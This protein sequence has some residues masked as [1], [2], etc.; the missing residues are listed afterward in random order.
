MI[1]IERLENAIRK[2]RRWGRKK[3]LI[4]VRG[5]GSTDQKRVHV[6]QKYLNSNNS[7]LNCTTQTTYYIAKKPAPLRHILDGLPGNVL[8]T[9]SKNRDFWDG[10]DGGGLA[11]GLALEGLSNKACRTTKIYKRLKVIRAADR[12]VVGHDG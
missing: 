6:N 1:E 4:E 3:D 10:S 2:R 11:A 12:A 8:R 9:G 7:V 5:K